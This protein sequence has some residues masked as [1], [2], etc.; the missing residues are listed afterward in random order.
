[1]TP[2]DT[3]VSDTATVD[4]ST[5]PFSLSVLTV[6]KGHASK[7]L[8]VGPT[9]SPSKGR[10]LWPSRPACS[11]MSRCRAWSGCSNCLSAIRPNQALVHGVVKGSHPGAVAPLV[12]TEALKQAK[13]GTLAPGTVARSLEHIAYPDGLFLLM[14]DHDDNPEDPTP[15]TTAEELLTRLT[16]VLPGIE[17]AGRLVTTSTSSGIKSKA[18]GEWLIPPTGFHLYLLVQG[19][20][21]RFVDL[22]TVRLWNAGYGYCKLATP[23]QQTGVAAVL[24]AGRGGLCAC[25]AR[26]PGLRGRGQD[27]QAAPFYQDRGAPQL[28]D[29]DIL[30]LDAF[31]DVTAEE[32]QDVHRARWPPPKR[33]WPPNG[34]P[35]SKPTVEATEPTLTPEQV[36]ASRSNGCVSTRMASSRGFSAVL[37]SPQSGRGGQGPLGGL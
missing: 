6:T 9:A 10:A 37:L 7:Q 28:V 18:T 13:P 36:S 1:M 2:L 35:R 30:D 4:A 12:T 26:A 17:T 19:N 23:N 33:R 3:C 31:P 24:D 32:R 22:L 11:S 27:R 29:G 21:Q 20:L 8:L 16:P 5:A 14:F 34:L 15:L 25:L